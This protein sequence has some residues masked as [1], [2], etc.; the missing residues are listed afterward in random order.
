MP[1]SSLL[2]RLFERCGHPLLIAAGLALWWALGGGEGAMLATA[3]A[4]LLAME[5]LERWR[6]AMPQWRLSGVAKLK[7]VGVYLFGV[8]VAALLV[9]LYEAWLPRLLAGARGPVGAALWPHHW[10]WPLQALLLFFV[11]DLIYYWVHRAI[12]RWAWLWRLTGHGFHHG[13]HNLHALNVGSNHPFEAVF[14]AL[15]LTLVAA[16]TGISA[17]IV[18]AAAM[19][20][21]LNTT[22]AHANLRL[23]TPLWNL[24][25]TAGHHHR[26][27]HSQ[28]FEHSNSNYACNAIVWDRVFG[29]FGRGAV[30]QTGIG[31]EQPSIWRMYLLPF[32]EPASADTVATRAKAPH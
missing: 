28:V 25:F 19:L 10:P 17:Q 9:G 16:L 15:P 8:V 12:H 31:P 21:L 29:T 27:H 26:R 24:F 7:L 23:H 11:G 20:S 4:L 2:V 14:L 6:P 32:R 1:R 13:F 3:A 22:L 18:A 5:G 30:E